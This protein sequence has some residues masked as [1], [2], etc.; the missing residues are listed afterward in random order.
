MEA[1]SLLAESEFSE[2]VRMLTEMVGAIDGGQATF[3]DQL[4]KSAE[5]LTRIVDINDIRILKRR[6]GIEIETLRK[7]GVDKR[8]S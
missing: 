2:L 4:D 5:R 7:L 8:A 3:H 6:L 1:Q